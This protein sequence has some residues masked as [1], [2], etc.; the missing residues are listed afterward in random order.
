MAHHPS[1]HRSRP[2]VAALTVLLATGALATTAVPA[3]RATQ[4]AGAA[5]TRTGTG[6]GAT[7][8][9]PITLPAPTGPLPVGTTTLH[10]VDPQRP[11]RWAPTPRPRELMAQLWYPAAACGAP[12]HRLA[13][14][15]GPA[16]QAHLESDYL[17]AAPGRLAWPVTHSRENAP[18]DRT[19]RHPVVLY[20]PGSRS[21]RSFGTL[22]AEDLASRGYV[23]VS[24]DHTFD[25]GEVAFPDGR[26]EVRNKPAVFAMTDEEI[27]AYRTADTRFVL[28][29]LTDLAAGTNPDAEQRPLPPGLGAALDLGAVGVAGHS[30]GGATAVQTLHDD[31]RVLAGASLDG[32][33]F[34]TV[35][36]DGLDRPLLLFGAADDRP[37][38]DAMWDSLWPRLTSWRRQLLMDGSGHGSFADLEVL[39]SAARSAMSWTDEEVDHL[40]GTVPPLRAVAAQR[41][42]LAAFFDLHLRH[43]PTP[44]FTVPSPANP[45]VHLVR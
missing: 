20:S 27:V 3:A 39:F 35:A 33:V 31:P 14:W 26:L 45:E 6:T 2:A 18:A 10:L 43:R 17:G 32:P 8:P 5:V 25:A 4:A 12:G 15:T 9:I 28:D 22:A 40:I 23:V 21:D 34:G 38:R 36:T 41:A 13:P 24:L 29:R 37:T 19:T 44:L 11:D 1:H 30:M 16:E 42:Y 7:V